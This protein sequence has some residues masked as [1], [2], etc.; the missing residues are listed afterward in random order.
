MN[1]EP[2]P[3][4]P[5]LARAAESL[6]AGAGRRVIVGLSGGVDSAVAALLLA[7][8]GW[9]VEGLFMSNWD[10]ADAYCTA[11]AD[12]QA[13][14]QV[15]AELD[16]PLHRVSFRERYRERVFGPFLDEYAAGRTPNPDVHCNREIKFD[17][18][19]QHARRLGA[20]RI[21]TGHYARLCPRTGALQQAADAGKDQTY[22]LHAVD[23]AALA[24]VLFP[25]GHLHKSQVRALAAE[26]GLPN[27]DRPD[28][29]GICFIGEGRFEPFLRRY[30]QAPAGPIETPEGREVGRHRGLCH[31]TIGQRRGLG[32]GGGQGGGAPW[33]VVD[34]CPARNALI[35]VQGEHPARDHDRVFTGP[36]HWLSQP[37]LPCRAQARLRHRQPLQPCHVAADG[38]GL[39]VQFEAPQRAVA[40]GQSLVLYAGDRCLGG[41]TIR[42]RARGGEVFTP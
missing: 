37:A 38:A 5:A 33:Y 17:A 20:A 8:A 4:L 23:P 14:R 1:A 28:S 19:L 39:A 31:Y 12:F 29:T 26:A 27:H 40:P 41:A 21:A 13:A 25:L 42:G 22:F 32:I 10:E 35:V 3:A 11:A 9:Q 30:L 34:K 18:F 16:I 6:P 36:A 15:C 7:Q 24:H 2:V